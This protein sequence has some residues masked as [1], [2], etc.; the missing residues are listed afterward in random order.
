[1]PGNGDTDPITEQTD[2]P[3]SHPRN[4]SLSC[5]YNVH[6]PCASP[7]SHTPVIYPRHRIPL[8]T[9]LQLPLPHRL[10]LQPT[11]FPCLQRIGHHFRLTAKGLL[12]DA[13]EGVRGGSDEEFEEV[14]DVGLSVEIGFGVWG[15]KEDEPVV[16]F[17][18]EDIW[19]VGEGVE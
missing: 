2:R 5:S 6:I 15:G 11:A 14:W 19:A 8:P 9:P 17:A 16:A 10:N 3:R 13:E 12:L 7:H 18:D 1:M 4:T